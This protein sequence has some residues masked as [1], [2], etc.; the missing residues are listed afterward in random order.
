MRELTTNEDED[1]FFISRMRTIPIE[2][3]KTA[4]DEMT[5]ENLLS[6]KTLRR[7][8]KKKFPTNARLYYLVSEI[9]LYGLLEKIWYQDEF[10]EA[11]QKGIN[12]SILQ[13]FE[14]KENL[15]NSA[16]G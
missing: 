5:L 15:E 7:L 13:I 4:L 14:T 11:D 16:Y 2:E 1:E 9:N 12:K 6:L 10:S 3:C 8:A